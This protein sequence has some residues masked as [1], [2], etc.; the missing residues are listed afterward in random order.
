MYRL[1]GGEPGT[2]WV[3][4]STPT[5]YVRNLMPIGPGL[6]WAPAFLLMTF[7]VWVG[8]IVG[9]NYPL[10]GYG[11]TVPGS[12]RSHRR[13][14]G[15]RRCLVLVLSAPSWSAHA[16]PRGRRSRCGCRRA[17]CIN[18]VISP[19]YSHAASLLTTSLFWWAFARGRERAAAMQKNTPNVEGERGV[20]VMTAS[21]AAFDGQIGQA[22][23]S[24]SKGG[25]VG[26]TLPMAR[27]LA[28]SRHPRD[29]DRARASSTRRWWQACQPKPRRRSASRCRSRRGSGGPTSTRALVRADRRE[30]HAQRRN[31]PP[32]RRD[33]DGAPLSS[34]D[35]PGP[36][37]HAGRRRACQEFDR[38][39]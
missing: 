28:S 26:M 1:K 19:T 22:A 37:G 31:H 10:D 38:R 11:A 5:G 30:P 39:I 18:S 23:Y 2:E 15:C 16:R 4:E 14:R 29:D 6:L 36:A 34:S 27:E 8:Q 33:P 3:Y 12:R 35:L 13:R 17:R 25:V 20:I 21:V 7:A 32:R 24:A 9:W